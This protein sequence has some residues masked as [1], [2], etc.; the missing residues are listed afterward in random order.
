MP[1]GRTHDRITLWS[2][3]AVAGLSFSLTRNGNLTLLVATGFLFGGLMF[4]PDLDIHSRQYQR[5]GWLRW[6]WQPYQQNLRHRSFLSH[7][8]L[9][10]T[11]LR[12]FYLASWIAALW[13]FA[14]AT[15]KLFWGW[16]W[17]WHSAGAAVA[18]SFQQHYTEWIALFAGLELGA[19]SHY[20]SDWGGSAYKRFKTQ[21]HSLTPAAKPSNRRHSPKTRQNRRS[22]SVPVKPRPK[23]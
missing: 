18:Q 21:R 5:W 12:V 23:N 7:G 6:I 17:N 11:A 16:H 8:P 10:G 22:K 20:L 3:P 13:I 1:S 19:M 9:I 4:G 14:A 2:L 15:G